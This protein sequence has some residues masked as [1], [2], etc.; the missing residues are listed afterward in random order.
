MALNGSGLF[1]LTFMAA[2]GATALALDLESETQLSV[3][4]FNDSITTPN[5]DTNTAYG[6]APFNANEVSGTGWSAGGVTLTGTTLATSSGVIT[7]D[8]TDV[9]QGGTTLTNAEGILI[10]ANGLAGDNAV[11]LLDHGSPVSTIAGTLTITWNA[12]GIFTWDVV[13]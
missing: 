7:F 4:L 10:Y 5:F 8:A 1:S 2:L 12:S 11:A 9:S 3:A 6:S 13:P